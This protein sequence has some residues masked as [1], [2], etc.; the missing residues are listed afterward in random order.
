MFLPYAPAFRIA[1]QIGAIFMKFGRAPETIVI[2]ILQ[3]V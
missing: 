1:R 3:K 2:F